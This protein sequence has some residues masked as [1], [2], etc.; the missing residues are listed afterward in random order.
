MVILGV[1]PGLAHTGWGIVEVRGQV[2]RCRAYGCIDTSKDDELHVRLHSIYSELSDVIERYKPEEMAVEELFFGQNVTSAIAVSHARGVVLAA[3]AASDMS[4]GEYTPNQIKQA[5]VGSGRADK[6]QVT[7]MVR[8]ILNLNH[9]P[10]PDHSAD[11]LAAAVCH[12]HMLRS[13]R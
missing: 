5:L 1:D 11:A 8:R 13:R 9:D 12:A 6:G 7:F 3:G 2:C 4:L 10:T